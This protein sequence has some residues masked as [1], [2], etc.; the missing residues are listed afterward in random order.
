[1]I[2]EVI[3]IGTEILIG[4][5]TNTNGPYLSRKLTDFGYEVRYHASVRDKY[6]DI[7]DAVE[8]AMTRSDVIFLCGGLGPTQDDMTK[9]A[10]AHALG[11]K[12][13]FDEE[14]WDYIV[15]VAMSF[16]RHITDNNKRQAEFP[17][18]AIIIENK[19]GSAPGCLL[20]YEGK[21]FFMLPG[22]PREF[23][24]MVDAIVDRYL[25]KV[26]GENFVT[27][28]RLVNIGESQ[29][30]SIFRREGIET[31]HV[32]V[33]TFAK[34]GEVEI[35]V[36]A[37]A[38]R[39]EDIPAIREE[40]AVAVRR[41]RTLFHDH[42]YGDGDKDMFETLVEVLRHEN[43]TISFAESVT[44]GAL[45]RMITSVAGASDVLKESYITY[46]NEV[47]EKLLQ[48]DPDT[49]EAYSVVSKEVAEEMSRGLYDR[50]QSTYTVATTGE[51][52]PVASTDHEVGTV[53]YSIRKNGE[54][55]LG[56]RRLFKGDRTTIQYRSS[57][58]LLASI[59]LHELGEAYG[60]K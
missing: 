19:K 49:I 5:I 35:K 43:M 17:E 13:V 42:I 37:H 10:L 56:G 1:M 23:E 45:V 57:K 36:L 34:T 2:S 47:K 11:L 18:G 39:E 16:S 58:Y 48:V 59:L 20:N 33:N 3:T 30:E 8:T 24:P 15:N 44:G 9:Q 25:K 55:I 12:L 21:Q 38:E 53:Y 32:E 28:L 4:S 41:L 46:S 27:S 7:R 6:E 50:T 60:R 40:H 51:A 14:Q 29:C 52:G 54:E 22:P 31:E 26:N